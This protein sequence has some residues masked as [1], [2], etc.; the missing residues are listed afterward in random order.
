LTLIQILFLLPDHHCNAT[1]SGITT[2]G[3]SS[4]ST[5]IDGTNFTFPNAQA[6][7]GSA[8]VVGTGNVIYKFSSSQRYKENI[9]DLFFNK[10]DFMKLMPK[11]F[12]FIGQ[13]K[14]VCGLIA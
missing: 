1:G 10:E 6:G 3:N 9:E 13:K 12:N 14:R 8:L 7:T 2:I 5:I 4:G 11:I